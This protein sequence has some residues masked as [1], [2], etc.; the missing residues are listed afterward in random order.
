MLKCLLS[1]SFSR[2][3]SATERACLRSGQPRRWIWFDGGKPHADPDRDE[4]ERERAHERGAPRTPRRTQGSHE[5]RR[6][7]GRCVRENIVN[8]SII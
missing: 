4:R 7:D 5:G 8:C 3:R 6:R 2:G 1:L